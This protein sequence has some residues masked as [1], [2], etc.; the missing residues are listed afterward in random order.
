MRMRLSQ[1]K[2]KKHAYRLVE[3]EGRFV[4]PYLQGENV[5]EKEKKRL[6]T[7]TLLEAGSWWGG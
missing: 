3:K 4:P 7:R 5:V 6:R 1:K 2:I